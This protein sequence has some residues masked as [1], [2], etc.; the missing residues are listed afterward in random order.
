M[1]TMILPL[2]LVTCSS[3][4]LFAQSI[5][6]TADS[7]ATLLCKKWEMSY[8]I[9]DG[10]KI[11]KGAG[12]PEMNYE[13]KKDKTFLITSNDGKSPVKGTWTYDPNMK[14]VKLTQNGKSNT[15]AIEL[16]EE[17]LV[18]LMDTKGATPGDSSPMKAYLKP[19]K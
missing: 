1:K 19:K 4:N 2:L 5:D 16:R 3:S 9:M 12:A 15:T 11:Q 17:E 18:M 10:M 7:V 6:L 13:F 14:T 8:I